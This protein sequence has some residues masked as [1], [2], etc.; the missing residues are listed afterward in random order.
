MKGGSYSESVA[1][2]VDASLNAE[3]KKSSGETPYSYYATVSEALAAAEEGDTVTPLTKE[4]ASLAD[5]WFKADGAQAN[6]AINQVLKS[7]GAPEASYVSDCDKNTMWSVIQGTGEEKEYT[8]KVTK[9]GAEIN[10][11]TGTVKSGAV[12]YF[13]FERD[14]HVGTNELA[15]RRLYGQPVSGRRYHHRRCH[16]GNQTGKGRF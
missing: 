13:T 5:A 3:L 6:E 4:S 8:V 7:M 9:D 15:S 10:T 11:W 12:V 16:C 1:D 2:Y 14:D